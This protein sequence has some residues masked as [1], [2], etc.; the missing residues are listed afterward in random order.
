METST[1][2]LSMSG[3]NAQNDHQPD[4]QAVAVGK[5]AQATALNVRKM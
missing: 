5:V 4:M 3:N 2:P 1:L